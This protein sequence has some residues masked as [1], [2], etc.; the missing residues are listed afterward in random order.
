MGEY[1]Q[2]R[3]K[4][5]QLSM[6]RPYAASDE[7]LVRRMSGGDEDAFRTIYGRCQ[8]P[9]FRFALHMSGSAAIAEDVTQEAFLFLIQKGFRFD[10][11]RGTL[12]AY[13]FG[14][15]RNLVLRRI[16]REQTTVSLAEEQ[17]HGG[18][19]AGSSRHSPA[20]MVEP[21]DL[22]RTERIERV[23]QATL[24]LPPNYREVVVLCDLQEMSY[25]Q[26]AAALGCAVG[27]IRSRLHRSRA[28]L[29]EKLRDVGR[30]HLK[31]VPGLQRRGGKDVP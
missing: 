24:S 28:L 18:N 4:P 20:F 3:D 15:A 12:Q 7:E 13:L 31:P 17:P 2:K 29:M 22:A 6:S 21:A 5:K 26:A 16:E 27:T 25:E 9:I 19:G 14:I 30:P 23:R 11:S 8:G 10:P 1:I